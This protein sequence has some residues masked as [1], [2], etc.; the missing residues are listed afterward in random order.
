MAKL[1]LWVIVSR[2]TLVTS[3][4]CYGAVML[5]HIKSPFIYIRFVYIYVEQ[6]LAKINKIALTQS[7]KRLHLKYA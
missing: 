3:Q 5:Y 6:W 7:E 4:D 2:Q 1:G